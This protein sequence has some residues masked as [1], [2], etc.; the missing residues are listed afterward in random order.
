MLRFC[1]LDH[2]HLISLPLP[3]IIPTYV[4]KT[5]QSKEIV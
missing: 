5:I 2:I 4:G 1:C 3:L